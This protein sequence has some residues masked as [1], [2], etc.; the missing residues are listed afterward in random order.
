MSTKF[1]YHDGFLFIFYKLKYK[2]R[3]MCMYLFSFTMT[4]KLFCI[5]I[6]LHKENNFYNFNADN[7]N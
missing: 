3:A 5:T 6:I 1:H 7:L 4:I 2:T